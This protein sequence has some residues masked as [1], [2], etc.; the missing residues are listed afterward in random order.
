MSDQAVM[1][2]TRLHRLYLYR[3]SRIVSAEEREAAVP[4]FQNDDDMG[5]NEAEIAVFGC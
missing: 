5:R 3:L 4:C 1:W 2:I